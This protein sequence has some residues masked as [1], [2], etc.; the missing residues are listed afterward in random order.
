M[1]TALFRKNI[2]NNKESKACWFIK[3]QKKKITLT[4]V[5]HHF[6]ISLNVLMVSIFHGSD[7]IMSPEV[8]DLKRLCSTKCVH[9][10]TATQPQWKYQ[11]DSIKWEIKVAKQRYY[12]RDNQ[13]M[14]NAHKTLRNVDFWDLCWPGHIRGGGRTNVLHHCLDPVSAYAGCHGWQSVNTLLRLHA[15]AQNKKTE[16]NKNIYAKG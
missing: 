10:L 8:L 12:I 7:W 13:N 5:W 6:V 3:A 14:T 15:A 4:L 2:L 16:M 11:K 9:S 1:Q